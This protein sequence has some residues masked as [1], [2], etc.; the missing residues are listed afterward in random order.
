[1]NPLWLVVFLLFVST[2]VVGATALYWAVGGGGPKPHAPLVH[3]ALANAKPPVARPRQRL[4]AQPAPAP[5]PVEEEEEEPDNLDEASVE[6]EGHL[7]F[8]RSV[9]LRR[10]CKPKL[11]QELIDPI[12]PLLL[13]DTIQVEQP[14]GKAVA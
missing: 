7:I 4:V 10:G 12:A 3:Q 13:R 9:L 6:A 1:M 2:A 5:A 11:V 14:T 8:I